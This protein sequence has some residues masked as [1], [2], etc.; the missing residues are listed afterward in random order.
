MKR[1][2]ILLLYACL[3][4]FSLSAEGELRVVFPRLIATDPASSLHGD[5]TILI[6]DDGFT[7][8]VDCG[9][10]DT[11]PALL[12]VLD[13][14][15]ITHLD[16][17]VATHQHI[18]HIGAFPTLCDAISISKVYQS[19][20]EY[21]SE[22]QQAFVRALH[23]HA[24]PRHF[25]SIGDSIEEHEQIDI[26]VLW[27]EREVIMPTVISNSFANNNSLVLKIQYQGTSVM[28]AGDLYTMGERLVMANYPDGALDC[29]IAKANH[30]GESTSNQKAWY[31]AVSPDLAVCTSDGAFN[32]A[33]YARLKMLGIEMLQTAVD[34]TIVICLGQDGY[35]ILNQG[36]V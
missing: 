33:V 8:M 30:H 35:Q 24:I 9:H 19:P 21:P 10:P 27:P 6:A 16:C 1:L 17:F 11:A 4:V 3:C 25:V 32:P 36:T 29:D 18:D 22:V 13:S 28:L 23:K 26:D 2:L 34:G 14:L 5:A 15:G 12:Q 31:V 7:M 20:V